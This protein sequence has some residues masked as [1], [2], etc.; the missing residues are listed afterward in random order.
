MLVKKPKYFPWRTENSFRLLINGDEFYLHML[1]AIDQANKIILLETYFVESG[2]VYNK[3]INALI[4]ASQ[5][6][7]L[8]YVIFDSMGTRGLNKKDKNAMINSDINLCLYH[9]IKLKFLLNNFYRDHRKLLLIDYKI[10][11]VGGAGISDHFIGTNHWRDNMLEIQGKVV[12]DWF[13]LFRHNWKKQ[14]KT[15]IDK[16]NLPQKTNRRY[17]A[18][19]KVCYSR[20]FFYNQIK[21][22]LIK[23][24]K[25]STVR[26]WLASAYFIPS[27]KLRRALILAAKRGVEVRLLLPGVKTDNYMS[28]HIGHGY[29]ARLLHSKVKIFEFQSRFIHSKVVM[30]DDWVTIGSSNLERW[31]ASWN[32]E[33]NQ[34]IQNKKFAQSIK[35]MFITDFNNSNEVTLLKWKHRSWKQK[36]QVWFWKYIG[37]FIAKI[38]LN[39]KE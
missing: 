22:S 10:A 5:R 23:Q 17:N 8:V 27:L 39:K 19:G 3:F 4:A 24:I 29:Y 9:P 38:G 1:Q 2:I 35:Q 32:L 34:E 7:V 16:F 36:S 18:L 21:S 20:G 11:F 14:N 12:K 31:G 33:A 26:I 37:K 25:K 13:N 6:G 30:I 15:T 28:R